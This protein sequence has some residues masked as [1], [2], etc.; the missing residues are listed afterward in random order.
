MSAS[1]SSVVWPHV[2]KTHVQLTG[3]K[4]SYFV[5]KF[6]WTQKDLIPQVNILFLLLWKWKK[7]ENKCYWILWGCQKVCLGYVFLRSDG[8]GVEFSGI[9]GPTIWRCTQV[10]KIQVVHINSSFWTLQGFFNEENLLSEWSDKLQWSLTH[11]YALFK[12]SWCKP[13][14]GALRH[15]WNR[16]RCCTI[17]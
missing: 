9:S 6:N 11:Y 12:Q 7:R 10:A 14:P 15:M 16:W 3:I 4:N 8:P 17:H 5:G 2:C 13:G 1:G